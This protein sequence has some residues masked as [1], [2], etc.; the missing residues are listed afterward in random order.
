MK[1]SLERTAGQ[2]LTLFNLFTRGNIP[3]ETVQ[4]V[5]GDHPKRRKQNKEMPLPKRNTKS[6]QSAQGNL[7]IWVIEYNP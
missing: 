5:G 4:N 6:A 1:K 7:P 3:V 2:D